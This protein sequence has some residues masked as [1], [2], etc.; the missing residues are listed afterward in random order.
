MRL[1]LIASVLALTAACSPVN[2]ISE[3]EKTD[4]DCLASQTVLAITAAIREGTA[5]GA[6]AEDLAA[7]PDAKITEARDQLKAK[8]SKRMDDAFLE[9]DINH[10]LQKIET[11]LRDPDE[12]PDAVAIMTETLA[13]GESCEFGGNT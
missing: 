3:A 12:E 7:I 13:L 2:P 8:Y 6:S 9:Y 1:A 5:N 11:A 4:I 10:R